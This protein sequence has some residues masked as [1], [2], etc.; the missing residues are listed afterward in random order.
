MLKRRIDPALAVRMDPE[1]IL[2]EAYLKAAR[3]FTGLQGPN[4]R[5]TY[6]WQL[7]ARA[8]RP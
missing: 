2:S 7:R 4:R 5:P 3:R 1:E 6:S 8:P